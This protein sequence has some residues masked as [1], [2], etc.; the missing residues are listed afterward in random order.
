MSYTDEMLSIY[1]FSHDEVQRYIKHDCWVL[2]R[3][4][5][6]LTG[7]T[8]VGIGFSGTAEPD[9]GYRDFAHLAVRTAHGRILD[10]QGNHSEQNFLRRWQGHAMHEHS[11]TCQMDPCPHQVVL[12][13]VKNDKDYWN[14]LLDGITPWDESVKDAPLTAQR[15]L[16]YYIEDHINRMK[17][18]KEHRLKAKNRR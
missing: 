17:Q 8:V 4:L 5:G 18:V 10:I 12:F 6:E 3:A 2:A 14:N 7:W 15:L 11:K 9:D 1:P 16:T 13:D